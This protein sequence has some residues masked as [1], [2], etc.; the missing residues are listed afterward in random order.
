MEG[1][2]EL[3]DFFGIDMAPFIRK[4]NYTEFTGALVAAGYRPYYVRDIRQ[5]QVTGQVMWAQSMSEVVDYLPGATPVPLR[6]ERGGKAGPD[7][8]IIV[9]KKDGGYVNAAGVI[10]YFG[11]GEVIEVL[12]QELT[13]EQ[14]RLA[15]VRWLYVRGLLSDNLE[16]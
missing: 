4:I 7:D 12:K 13:S 8:A 1:W 6:L 16:E 15:F 2:Y 3:S 5:G 11:T 9:P 14:K 10:R